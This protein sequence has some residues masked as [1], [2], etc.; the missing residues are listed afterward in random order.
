M[1]LYDFCHSA[2]SQ[3]SLVVSPLLFLIKSI[4]LD[5]QKAALNNLLSLDQIIS[6]KYNQALTILNFLSQISLSS[7]RKIRLMHCNLTPDLLPSIKTYG[8]YRK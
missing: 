3:D 1:K 6:L 8:D 4:L 5:Y 2:N 7:Y